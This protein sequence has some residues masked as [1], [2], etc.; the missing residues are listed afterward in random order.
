[1]QNTAFTATEQN[2]FRVEAHLVKA[3]IDMLKQYREDKQGK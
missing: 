3:F 2:R 1:M